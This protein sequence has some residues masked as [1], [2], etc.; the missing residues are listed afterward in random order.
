MGLFISCSQAL[1][2]RAWIGCI[3]QSGDSYNIRQLNERKMTMPL[4]ICAVMSEEVRAVCS[5]TSL[6]DLGRKFNDENVDGF[7]VIDDGVFRGEVS[8]L[9]VLR[10]VD[11]ERADAE[12]ATGFWEE[13]AGIESPLPAMEWISEFV[14]KHMDHLTVSDVMNAHPLTVDPSESLLDVAR[15]MAARKMHRVFVLDDR[16]LVGVVSAYDFLR[17]YA[18]GLIHE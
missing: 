1:I 8:R 12:M 2:A 14:G 4:N 13:G 3:P 18:D 6:P 9:D 7:A 17:L 10:R 5:T 16:R 15:R 11:E